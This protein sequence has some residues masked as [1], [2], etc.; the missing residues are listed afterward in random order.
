M[1][2]HL[3]KSSYI[4]IYISRHTSIFL[5]YQLS[6]ITAKK[7]M[8]EKDCDFKYCSCPRA[9]T[10][11]LTYFI[12]HIP[13]WGGGFHIKLLYLLSAFYFDPFRI[14]SSNKTILKSMS[15]IME[16]SV[17]LFRTRSQ[18]PTNHHREN[19]FAMYVCWMI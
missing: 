4:S 3:P 18:K 1:N 6:E 7:A 14:E 5:A 16:V 15:S 8:R 10:S 17:H 19:S 2:T 12:S 13:K 9:R 11:I